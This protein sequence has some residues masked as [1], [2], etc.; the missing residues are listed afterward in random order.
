MK[1][2]VCIKKGPSVEHFPWPEIPNISQ[3]RGEFTPIIVSADGGT[4][5]QS[6]TLP[7]LE[8]VP[9]IFLFQGYDNELEPS[10]QA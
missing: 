9:E 7:I 2:K 4:S 10:L 8:L 1:M 3:D 5:C 6:C